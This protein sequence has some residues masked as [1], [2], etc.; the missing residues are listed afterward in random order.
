MHQ[1]RM[2]RL[3]SVRLVLPFAPTKIERLTRNF[4]QAF[5]YVAENREEQFNS[6]MQL[7][8]Q[9]IRSSMNYSHAMQ[10]HEFERDSAEEKAAYAKVQNYLTRPTLR[11]MRTNSAVHPWR[12]TESLGSACSKNC[13]TRQV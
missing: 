7:S 1:R 8:D 4:T 5:E 9:S 12:K 10:Q 3:T 2:R 6:S 11:A 13:E